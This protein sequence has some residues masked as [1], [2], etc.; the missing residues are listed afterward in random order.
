LVS[1]SLLK[2][3]SQF[4]QL[5]AVHFTAQCSAVE[6]SE[7]NQSWAGGKPQADSPFGPEE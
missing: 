2:Q 5:L 1:S 4:Y 3:Y 7:A 6:C